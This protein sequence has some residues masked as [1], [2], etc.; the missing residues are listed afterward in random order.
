MNGK[1]I[2]KMGVTPDCPLKEK[3][4]EWVRWGKWDGTLDRL[5]RE[6]AQAFW[7]MVTEH[8]MMGV[9]SI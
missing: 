6:D 2:N 9:V 7:R 5:Q 8:K 4:Y 3:A 1:E